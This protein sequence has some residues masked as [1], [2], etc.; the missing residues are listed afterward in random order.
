MT[1]KEK[2]QY[3]LDNYDLLNIADQKQ[4]NYNLDEFVDGI[5]GTSFF[6]LPDSWQLF[7]EGKK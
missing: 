5:R 2:L 4:L 1:Y 3:L 7:N 6:E